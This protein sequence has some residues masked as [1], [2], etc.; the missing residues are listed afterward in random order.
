M[1]SETKWGTPPQGLTVL[2]LTLAAALVGCNDSNGASSANGTASTSATASTPSVS[3]TLPAAPT[4]SDPDTSPGNPSSGSS[5]GGSSG[6][7]G[8]GG[9]GSS[10][11]VNVLFEQPLESGI[12]GHL[13]VPL[14]THTP[15]PTG[16]FELILWQPNPSRP[17]GELVPS[18]WN[19]SSQTGLTLTS[20]L[21]ATQRGFQDK[22]GTT[23]AQMDGDTVGAYLNSEDLPSS[24]TGQ[25]MMITPQFSFV[26]GNEPV[27]FSSSNSSLSAS[28]DLQVPTALGTDTYVLADFLFVDPNGVRICYGVKL[29]TNGASHPI[30]GTNYNVDGNSY[31]LNSPLG[32]DERFVTKAQGSASATGTPWLGWQHFEWSISQSQFAAALNYLVAQFPAKVQSTDPAQ[33]VLAQVHLNAEFHFAP[34]PAELGWSMRGWKIWVAESGG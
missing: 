8:T 14:A 26:P 24:P 3:S 34:A 28:M 10:S 17:D 21:T 13:F 1:H 15:P 12:A 7:S 25:K 27:P 11:G 4:S 31:E 9:S 22:T 20:S 5:G 30:V 18:E 29:F 23:T 33:Y 19:A 2:I 16:V 32:V 6:S